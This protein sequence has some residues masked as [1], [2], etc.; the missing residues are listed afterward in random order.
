[1]AHVARGHPA[2]LLPGLAT[3]VEQLGVSIHAATPVSEIRPGEARTAAGT[4]RTRWVVRATE[5]YTAR[6]PGLRRALVPMNSSMIITQPLSPARWE[7]IGW[8]GAEVIPTRHMCTPICSARTPG[9]SRAAGAAWRQ[10]S[11]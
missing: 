6:L 5:G 11:T 2:K 10:G 8:R 3:A 9:A 4:V 1:A 7:Q